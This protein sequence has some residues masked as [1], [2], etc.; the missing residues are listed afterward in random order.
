MSTFDDS[1]EEVCNSQAFFDIATAG[2][3]RGLGAIYVKH[4]LFQQSK[5]WQEVKLQ[6]THF[7]L[8]KSP[9]DVMQVST[10]SAQ[11]GLRSELVD[12]YRE[13]SSVPYGHLLTD[14]PPRTDDRL[15]FYTITGSFPSK[16]Y[17]LD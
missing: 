16:F 10:V 15:R 2:R 8:F 13:A 4:N 1:C 6:N 5:D 12:G 7:V 3:H 11:L 17:I 14:L 9:R